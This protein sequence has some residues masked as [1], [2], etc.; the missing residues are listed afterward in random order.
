VTVVVIGDEIV[1]AL[2]GSSITATPAG[3]DSLAAVAGPSS[4][5]YPQAP[6]PA[7]VV[8]MCVRASTLRTRLWCMSAMYRSPLAA[9]ATSLGMFR[10]A[11]VAGP[12]SPTS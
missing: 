3:P 7:T 1:T 4:P 11:L 10:C 2:P 9:I 12:P 8:M 5:E 6:V